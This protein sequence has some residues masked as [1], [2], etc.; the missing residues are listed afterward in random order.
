MRRQT[1]PRLSARCGLAWALGLFAGV[2]CS[3]TPRTAEE[4]R[5][6]TA[7]AAEPPVRLAPPQATQPAP[8][9]SAATPRVGTTYFDDVMW[10][11][12]RAELVARYGEDAGVLPRFPGPGRVLVVHRVIAGVPVE[13]SFHL[14]ARGL[15][16][17]ELGGTDGASSSDADACRD[18]MLKI[19][20]HFAKVAG[21][22]DARE[23]E[24]RWQ[25]P[26]ASIVLF[27][28]GGLGGVIEPAADAP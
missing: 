7:P 17:I 13:I 15:S 11:S 6:A 28:D 27:C 25:R 12:S 19:E 3:R 8:V 24:I 18:D 21:R 2:A 20:A 5:P 1:R 10:G 9:T 4:R 23:D 22:P 26:T 14:D 16:M